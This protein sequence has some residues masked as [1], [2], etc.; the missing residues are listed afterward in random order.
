MKLSNEKQ[1]VV[2]ELR[3]KASNMTGLRSGDTLEI[4]V[5]H[6]IEISGDQAWISF[7]ASTVVGGEE[8]DWEAHQRL[9][10]YVNNGVMKVIEQ[11]VN[12]VNGVGQ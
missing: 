10:E 8:T 2:E 9:N 4:G 6:N 5:S 12:T 3:T 1:A 7:K 11:A